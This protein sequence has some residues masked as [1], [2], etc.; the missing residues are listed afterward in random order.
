MFFSS[1][2]VS[3]IIYFHIILPSTNKVITYSKKKVLR[4]NILIVTLFINLYLL[5]TYYT[6][7][8]NKYHKQLVDN[9]IDNNSNL[10]KHKIYIIRLKKQ[11]ISLEKY[12][13]RLK[14]KIASLKTDKNNIIKNLKH[15]IKKSNNEIYNLNIILEVYRRS[16]IPDV[17]FSSTFITKSIYNKYISQ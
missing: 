17:G 9:I 5:Q 14:N 2:Y 13:T 12:V 4:N 11:I 16:T 1:V 7:Q 10:R 6:I 15:Q 3:G 8:T